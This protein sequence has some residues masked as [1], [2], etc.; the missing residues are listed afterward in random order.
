MAT[1]AVWAFFKVSD[2]DNATAMCNKCSAEVQRGG[3]RST[4]FNTSNLFSHLKLHQRNDGVW[5]EYK[6]AKA[7]AA[8]TTA[9]P[10][11]GVTALHNTITFSVTG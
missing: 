1:S 7:T 6:D 8:N 5:K 10:V 9:P 11:L 3:K 4:S 2:E